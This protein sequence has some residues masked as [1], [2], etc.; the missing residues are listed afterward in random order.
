MYKCMQLW[1]I[2]KNR[3]RF[4]VNA[5]AQT[6]GGNNK[7]EAMRIRGGRGRIKINI[8]LKRTS[9]HLEN[10]RINGSLSQPKGVEM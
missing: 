4:A 1:S 3:K 9:C 10:R 7:A 6:I 5:D 2:P 8:S